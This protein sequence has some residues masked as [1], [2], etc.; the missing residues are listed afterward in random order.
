MARNMENKYG[1]LQANLKKDIEKKRKRFGDLKTP[2]VQ[3]F[4]GEIWA[5]GK[6]SMVYVIPE[7][8]YTLPYEAK[9]DMHKSINNIFNSVMGGDKK[10]LVFDGITS[11]E[12]F[13]TIMEFH[14]MGSYPIE[15]VYLNAQL[16]K[17]FGDLNKLHFVSK[18]HWFSPVG[19]FKRGVLI[20][21]ICPLK[22]H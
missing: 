17:K 12:N 14:V 13:K 5:T 10:D 21:V 15:K 18:G 3:R 1:T 11:N 16:V 22:I 7:N 9:E 6:A 8:K 19:V 4:H 2:I 20:G